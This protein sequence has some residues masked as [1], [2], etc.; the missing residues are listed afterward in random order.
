M[1]PHDGRKMFAEL[2]HRGQK[3]IILDRETVL[4]GWYVV[5]P[6]VM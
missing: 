1:R 3:N 5:V 4:G 2:V 6:M